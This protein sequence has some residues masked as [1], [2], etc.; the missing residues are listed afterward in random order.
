MAVKVSLPYPISA[1]RYWSTRIVRPIGKPAIAMTYVSPEAK[2]FK[3]EVGW[4]LKKAGVT[5]PIQGRIALKLFLYPG[6]PLDYKK[7]MAKLGANWDDGVRCIDLDN[8][9][10][11]T[12]D[13]L[14]GI[15]FEDDAWVRSIYAERM[16][17]DTKGARLEIEISAI[18]TFDVQLELNSSFI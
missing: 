7:R 15:S 3:T 17:P 16:E 2:M 18:E 6:M 9:I 14:K 10:K 8:A 4:L 1:N 12:L 5:S 13:A 11:V